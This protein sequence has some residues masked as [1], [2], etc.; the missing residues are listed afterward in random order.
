MPKRTP[1]PPNFRLLDALW[2]EPVERTVLPNGLTVILKPDHS[3]ALASVQAW[4]KTGSMHEGAWLGA[5]LSHFLEHMLFKGTGR[6]TGPEISATIQAHGGYLNAYTTF[7]RTVY[8]VDLPSE[9]LEVAVDVLADAVLHSTVPEG[10]VE[11][12]RE[13]ILR[14]IAMTRDDPDSRLWETLFSTAFREHPYRHP[15]IG[16]RDVFAAVTRD[17]L[18]QYYRTRYVPD[19]MV[20]VLVGD[21]EPEIAR[22]AVGRHFGSA[23]R[24]RLAPATVAA[25][26]GQLAPREEHRFEDVGLTRAVLSW[27]IPGLAHPDAPVLDLLASILGHGDSSVLWSEVREKAGLVHEIHATSWNPGNCG[28]FCVSFT[29]DGPK[30]AAAVEAIGGALALRAAR[31]FTAAQLAKALRQLVVGEVN[32][33]K[34]MSGQASRLGAAEVVVGDLDYSRI[35][36]ERV[37]EVRPGDLRRVLRSHLASQRRTAV[38][39]NPAAGRE[40]GPAPRPG[41]SRTAPSFTETRLQNGARIL[42]RIDRRLPNVHLR[43]LM[44]GG[45]LFEEPGRR[46]STALLATMLTKDTRRRTAAAVARFVEE[47][48]GSFYPFSGNNSLG[49]CSEVLPGDLDRALAV[50]RD[51]ML[52]P[53]FRQGTFELERAAQLAGLKEDADDVVTMARKLLRLRFFGSH[54]MALDPQG[55]ADGVRT[56]APGDLSALHGRLSQAPNVVVAASGDFDPERMLRGL[57]TFL[58]R[59]PAGPGPKGWASAGNPTLPEAAGDHVEAR[60]C[61]QAVVLQAYP[62]PRLHAPDYYAGEVLDELFSG[63][64]SRLFE[65]V[66][67]ERG[68]AY[69]VRSERVVGTESGMFCF[70]AGTRPGREAEVQAEIDSEIL[71]VQSG[72]VSE[73]E[74]QRCR[75]RLKAAWRQQSQTNSAQALRAGLDAL[76]GRPVNDADK[77]DGRVDAVSG[78]DVRAFAERY[79]QQALRVRLV[80]KPGGKP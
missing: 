59:L 1:I 15:I 61:E 73:E 32:A 28:L 76:Q 31:G 23:P 71:R 27:P 18:V 4:V 14:E 12:E 62:S 48:G 8:H 9:H 22:A 33:R 19:N 74:L 54:P 65:R 53:A 78:A 72:E 35:Y 55:D 47:V 25:E 68:L 75:E 63:M 10:E 70:L 2:R 13:V 67:G 17:E 51:A 57:E 16:H 6:R 11:R 41:G 20:V 80:V 69:F 44:R 64:A 36:F 24:S 30:R 5:G 66:R 77:Y 37:R 40:P 56:L 38:S 58:A 39:I 43:V 21:F 50:I 79:F 45:A 42:L 3:A 26:P 60:P 49:L 52:S 7:D 29:C 34:T 46:G